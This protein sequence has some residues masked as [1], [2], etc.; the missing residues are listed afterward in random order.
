MNPETTWKERTVLEP[1]RNLERLAAY[2]LRLAGY[3][4]PIVFKQK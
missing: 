1:F 3:E 4:Q 2:E